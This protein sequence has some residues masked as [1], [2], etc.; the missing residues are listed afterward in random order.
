MIKCFPN[1]PMHLLDLG[2]MRKLLEAW[3]IGGKNYVPGSKLSSARISHLNK[4]IL[5]IKKCIPNDFGDRKCRSLDEFKRWKATELRLFRLYIGPV[6]LKDI[7]DENVYQHFLHFHVASKILSIEHL[8]SREYILKYCQNLFKNF[9]H[10][11]TLLYGPHFQSFNVHNL[12]HLPD[13]VSHFGV[14]GKF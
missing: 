11:S 12:I 7:V 14:L 9:V 1:D 2:I 13:D 8:I 6:L 10:E 3:I 5:A 4:Q